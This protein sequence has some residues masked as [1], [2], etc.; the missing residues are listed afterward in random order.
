MTS[1]VGCRKEIAA[2]FAAVAKQ[3]GGFIRKEEAIKLLSSIGIQDTDRKEAVN[4][5]WGE[6]RLADDDHI[7]EASVSPRRI[8][9]LGNA[10]VHLSCHKQLWLALLPL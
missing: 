7:T 8:A 6:M 10:A 9:S 1:W 4:Q 2:T 5:L 3:H